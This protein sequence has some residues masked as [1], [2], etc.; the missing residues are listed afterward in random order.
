MVAAPA[1]GILLSMLTQITD[2]RGRQ[3]RRHPLAAMLAAII[4]G[5]LTGATGYKAIAQW[6]RSQT[7]SVWKW[8]GFRRKPPCANSFRNLLMALP[9]ETLEG[10]LRVWVDSL[11]EAIR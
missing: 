4:C 10:V 7:P 3:G 11:L 8:L 9:P 5:L 2:P 6:T 1:S